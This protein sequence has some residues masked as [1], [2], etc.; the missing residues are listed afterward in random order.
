MRLI[1]G[2]PTI[3]PILAVETG[4]FETTTT[5]GAIQSRITPDNSKKIELAIT[6]FDKYV[7]T[8]ALDEKIVTFRSDS[9]TRT[10]FCTSYPNGQKAIRNI[11]CYPKATTT[12]Y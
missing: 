8:K 9:I 12:A 4:T 7:D 6:V 11:S 1:E 2:S 10:C 5:V 3:I